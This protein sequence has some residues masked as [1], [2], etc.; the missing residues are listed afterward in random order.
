MGDVR[1]VILDVPRLDS[2]MNHSFGVK[3]MS[4]LSQKEFRDEKAAYAFVEA[5]V[6]PDGPVCP[7]CGGMDRIGPLCGKSTRIGVYKC[8]KCRKPFTVKIGTIF[9][10]SKVK[11]HLWLQAIYLIAA[12]KRGISVNQLHRTLGVT[13][14]TAWFMGH[15]IREAM[16]SGDTTLI[17]SD[18]RVVDVNETFA[19][20]D[21]S[22]KRKDEKKGRG[23][24]HKFKVMS[25]I[26]RTASRARNMVADDLKAKSLMR[27]V[28][29][30]TCRE[31]NVMASEGEQYTHWWKRFT[32][33][34]IVHHNQGE[35]GRSEVHTNTIEV[36]RSIFKRGMKGVYQHFLNRH[37]YRYLTVLDSRYGNREVNGSDDLVRAELVVH[38]IIARKLLYRD[39]L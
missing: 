3:I 37:L 36:Y 19:G 1:A 12:N 35:C 26:N 20:N 21:R 29:E 39:L 11:M 30:N 10:D 16:R 31:V 2:Y 24:A 6:W 38:A 23:Y 28:Q 18:G 27:I 17:G 14:K 4:V 32:S 34:G 13:L 22:I 9:E 8:Y 15:R 25:L 5:H 33:Y 7:R